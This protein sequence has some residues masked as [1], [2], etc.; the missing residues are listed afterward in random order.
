M[1]RDDVLFEV[2][3]KNK[4]KIGGKNVFFFWGGIQFGEEKKKRREGEEEEEEDG[5]KEKGREKIG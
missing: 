5:T 3:L 1:I 4:I 2:Q